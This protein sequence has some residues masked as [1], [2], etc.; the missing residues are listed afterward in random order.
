M[1]V[2][3]DDRRTPAERLLARRSEGVDDARLSRESAQTARTL[4]GYFAASAPPRWSERLAEI[5][6]RTDRERRRLEASYRRLRRTCAPGERA[7]RWRARVAAWPFDEELNDLI[8]VHNEWYPI[9]R[10]LP[11]DPRTRDYVRVAG[12]SFRR[13]ELG[14]EWALAEFPPDA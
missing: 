7:Q 11:F 5:D 2:P 12:R 1:R 6:Q 13:P 8:R 10:R 14:P 4:E 9:E 3:A